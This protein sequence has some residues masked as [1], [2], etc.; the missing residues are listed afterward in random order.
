[1]SNRLQNLGFGMLAILGVLA[2]VYPSFATGRVRQQADGIVVDS[3]TG[4][5]VAGATVAARSN[6]PNEAVEEVAAALNGSFRV[7]VSRGHRMLVISA[8]GYATY[9]RA[10]AAVPSGAVVEMER[11]AVVRGTLL[12]AGDAAPLPGVITAVSQHPRNYVTKTV[13]TSDGRFEIGDLLPGPTVLIARAQGYGAVPTRLT[14]N[15]GQ[16][17]SNLTITLE[18]SAMIIGRV[19]DAAGSPAPGLRIT[20]LYD[21][22][23]DQQV[24]LASFVGGQTVTQADGTFALRNVTSG[25][26]LSLLVDAGSVAARTGA[27]TP[28]PG[29]MVTSVEMTLRA[30]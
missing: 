4:L 23:S 16:T 14:L 28:A 24:L 5:P 6:N 8:P 3:L 26:P 15:L 13:R 19:V 29:D 20:P 30:K 9:R 12:R 1:M 2:G 22:P 10:F 25:I 21:L 7:P 11:E 17:V 18:R 27:M